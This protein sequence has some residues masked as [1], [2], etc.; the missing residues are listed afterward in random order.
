MTFLLVFQYIGNCAHAVWCRPKI[1]KFCTKRFKTYLF[2]WRIC[3]LI[4]FRFRED[5]QLEGVL[6]ASEVTDIDHGKAVQLV[7]AGVLEPCIK[8]LLKVKD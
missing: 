5:K 4:Q 7:K 8:S 3:T 6:N 1:E 2:S